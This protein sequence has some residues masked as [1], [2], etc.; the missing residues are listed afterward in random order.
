MAHRKEPSDR[1]KHR[2]QNALSPADIALIALAAL[3][4]VVAIAIY[5]TTR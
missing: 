4:A 2:R 1:A 5:L 3:A